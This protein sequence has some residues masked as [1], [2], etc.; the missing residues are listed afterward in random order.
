LNLIRHS[1]FVIRISALAIFL[2]LLAGVP[3]RAAD[4]LSARGGP[5][6]VGTQES[7]PPAIKT[8]KVRWAFKSQ[9]HFIASP[10]PTEKH[11]IV[12]ALGA[13]NSA[14]VHAV[15]IDDIPGKPPVKA[16]TVLWS[17]KSPFIKL[18]TVSA[19][20][21]HDGMVIM[22]DGMHTTDGG[23]IYSFDLKTGR[24]LWRYEIQG[25]LIHLEG[26]PV[27]DPPHPDGP[28][29]YMGAGDGGVLAITASRAVVDGK[30]LKLPA[31]RAL[32]EEKW[33]E[34]GKRYEDQK[35]KDPDFAKEPGDEDLP[36]AVPIK[37]WQSGEKQWH[38]DAPLAI[39]NTSIVVCSSF[40]DD[41][42]I[43]D[44]SVI[45]VDRK[46]GAEMWK[47][48]VD[49][50]PWSGASVDG[51][52]IVVGCS[53]VRFDRNQVKGAKGALVGFDLGTGRLKYNIPLT[54]GV[55]SSVAIRD[56]VAVF[57]TTD[58]KVHA[59]QS[60][61]GRPLW[62][63]HGKEPFFAGAA[64]AGGVNGGGIVYAADV[65]GVLHA[66]SLKD[67][68]KIWT[69]D[70]GRDPLVQSPGMFF[71]SPVVRGEEIFVAT[72]N[73]QGENAD[74]PC[75]VAAICDKDYDPALDT[76]VKVT[77]DRKNRRIDIPALMAPRKLPNLKDIYPL[78]VV[79]T[80]PTPAGQKAHETV[81]VTEVK[82]SEVQKALESLGLKPGKPS[83]GQ[84]VPQGPELKLSLIMLAPSG[85]ERVIPIEKTILDVRT[86]KTLPELTWRFTG[87]SLRTD[88]DT[89]AKAYG[90]DLSGTF[91]TIYPV[92]SETVIQG[93]LTMSD[94]SAL[95]LE[96]NKNVVP[97]ENTEV[98]LRIEVK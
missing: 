97:E 39:T 27:V 20:A 75:V 37:L 78:E 11:L 6:R 51:D 58:G 14:E 67:G 91:M 45:V 24:A 33:T 53:S 52:T 40:L 64:I 3:S 41:E 83:G 29:V 56:N 80:W 17:K 16:G 50:N 98:K 93:S 74:K 7:K 12:S 10:V 84:E 62:T 32:M 42:K 63:Y 30:E 77:V 71:G 59:V 48:P 36:K 19:P 25:K 9:S 46:T 72:C 94:S 61:N 79:C 73:V 65:G 8:P 86:G 49:I 82:P 5:A 76:G 47:R 44:R 4:W 85:R 31:I 54:G 92:S 35:R 28:A 88:A 69:H 68:S 34:L 2:G 1:S 26:A 90:A 70:V 89:G 23:G 43:G 55:L 18:P 66:I 87:S 21:I 22:G 57:C 38:V 13:F 81:V 96:L 15:A 95:K 60:K